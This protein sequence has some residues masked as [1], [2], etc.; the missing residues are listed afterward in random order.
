MLRLLVRASPL[1]GDDGRLS[2][3][4]GGGFALASPAGASAAASRGLL[5]SR[6]GRLDRFCAVRTDWLKHCIGRQDVN[7][8]QRLEGRLVQLDWLQRRLFPVGLGF[9]RD[10]FGRLGG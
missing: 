8:F 7:R 5:G 2:G 4:F 1:D 9:G 10:R 3:R 6:R